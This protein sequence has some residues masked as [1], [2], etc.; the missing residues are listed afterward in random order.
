LVGA[1]GRRGWEQGVGGRVEEME[2]WWRFLIID[3]IIVGFVLCLS[4]EP[5]VRCTFFSSAARMFLLDTCQL[6]CGGGGLLDISR[7]L[8]RAG[9]LEKFV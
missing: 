5:F 3:A 6:C 9:R 8:P 2:A 4:I 1:V 7:P